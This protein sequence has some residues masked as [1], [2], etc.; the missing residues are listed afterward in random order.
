M[1]IRSGWT[2]CGIA[3]SGSVPIRQSRQLLERSLADDRVSA[4]VSFDLGLSQAFDPASVAAIDIPMLVIGAGSYQPGM[5]VDAESRDLAAML[6]EATT[7]YQESAEF[8][9]FTFFSECR[10]GAVTMLIAIGE[11]D[12]MIC[13]DGGER[14]RADLHAELVERIGQFLREAGF[15]TPAAG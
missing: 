5:P 10:P 14:S 9:H 1:P 2:A 6:P 13:E 11:G 7:T 15:A 8:T 12:E 3:R 4:V